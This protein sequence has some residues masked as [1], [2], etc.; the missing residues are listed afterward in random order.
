MY[1]RPQSD[2]RLEEMWLPVETIHCDG[3]NPQQ[4][5]VLHHPRAPIIALLMILVTFASLSSA[6]LLLTPAWE[7]NDE[8][9]HVRNVITLVQGEWYNIEDGAG[10]EAHQPPLYYLLLAVWHRALDLES[11]YPEPTSSGQALLGGAF[12]NHD[13]DDAASDDRLARALRIPSVVAGLATVALTYATAHRLSKNRWTPVVAAAFVATL[14]KFV[15]LA[16]VVNNDNLVA[17]LGAAL[18]Y[19]VTRFIMDPP[20]TA[21]AGRLGGAAIGAV[22]GMLVLTKVSTIPLLVGA[23]VAAALIGRRQQDIT[24]V[25]VAFTV[26]TVTVTGWWL[27]RNQARYGDPLAAKASNEYFEPLDIFGTDVEAAQ[28]LLI[29]IP[30]TVYH[31]FYYTSGWNQFSWETPWYI[32]FWVLLGA[33]L[34]ALRRRPRRD[35]QV[36]GQD[37]ALVLVSALVLGALSSLWIVGVANSFSGTLQA[38]LAFSGLAALG[39]LFALGLERAATPVIFSFVLPLLGLMGTSYALWDDVWRIFHT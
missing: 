36:P 39:C 21:L 24:G 15:F 7:A 16:G 1:A 19:L 22:Y 25:G 37:I 28:R 35:N 23:A 10:L 5:S 26:A 18:A 6:V 11:R 27:L 20:Q 9:D 3:S 2:Y 32:P 17:L 34:I 8:P 12:F 4:R 30:K 29:D 14:P 33:G 31:S 13:Y 38:R